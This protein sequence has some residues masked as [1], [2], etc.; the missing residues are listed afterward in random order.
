MADQIATDFTSRQHFSPSD[1]HVILDSGATTSVVGD[2]TVL[3]DFVSRTSSVKGVGGSTAST[4]S[5]L[6]CI[7]VAV[8]TGSPVELRFDNTLCI[9]GAPKLLSITRMVD[10]GAVFSIQRPGEATL[11]IGDVTISATRSNGLFL[12]RAATVIPSLTPPSSHGG[13]YSNSD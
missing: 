3:H 11:V 4:G 10:G 9:P 12:L 13:L 2:R 7:L 5:G 8:D 1:D 6:L